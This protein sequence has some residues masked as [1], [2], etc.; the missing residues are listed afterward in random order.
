MA[1][2][3]SEEDARIASEPAILY[4]IQEG[5]NVIKI[6]FDNTLSALMM[7]SE[8]VRLLPNVI[9]NRVVSDA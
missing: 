7:K 2:I 5:G 8:I 6:N 4:I 1:S 9:Y 3:F